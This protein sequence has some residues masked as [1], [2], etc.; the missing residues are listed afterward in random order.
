VEGDLA[1]AVD[2]DDRGAVERPLVGLG[3]LSGGVDGWVLEEERGVGNQVVGTLEEQP[4]LEVPRLL[5]RK[6]L[7]AIPVVEDPHVIQCTAAVDGTPCVQARAATLA[8]WNR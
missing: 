6:R 1:A 8:G 5:V 2:V 4:T 3:A 7:V